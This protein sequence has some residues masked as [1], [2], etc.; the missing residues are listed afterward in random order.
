MKNSPNLQKNP[1]FTHRG[2]EVNTTA[3]LYSTKRELRFS[4]SSNHTR[5]VSEIWDCENPG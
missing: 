1:S 4:A 5:G 2:K 3:Q